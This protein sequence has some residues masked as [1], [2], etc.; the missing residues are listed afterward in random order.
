MINCNQDDKW[1]RVIGEATANG[2]QSSAKKKLTKFGFG[3][4]CFQRVV[5][6]SMGFQALGLAALQV[7]KA[8][9]DIA[10]TFWAMSNM[11]SAIARIWD[12]FFFYF[13]V[14]VAV[15]SAIFV[16]IFCVVFALSPRSALT[17]RREETHWRR[18]SQWSGC[19]SCCCCF[20]WLIIYICLYAWLR[21][22]ISVFMNF[23]IFS[24]FSIF[25]FD[26]FFLWN[27]DVFFFWFVTLLGC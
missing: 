27:R 1:L 9:R 13:F 18:V 14:V 16:K 23:P 25:L 26:N 6:I 20:C 11:F 24:R 10:L 17:T 15:A 8:H 5:C 7:F 22:C 21:A 12:W 3:L 2:S 19:C 4:V